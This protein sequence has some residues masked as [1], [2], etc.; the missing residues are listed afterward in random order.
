MIKQRLSNEEVNFEVTNL[1]NY[2]CPVCPRGKMTREKGVMDLN[3]FK[4]LI[5]AGTQIGLKRVIL[6]GFGEPFLDKT[7]FEKTRY[8]K[9]YGLEVN[10]ATNGYLLNNE[11]IDALLES[12]LDELR[13]S[14]FS[15][16]P[17]LYKK[18]HGLDGYRL[19]ANNLMLLLEKRKIK[20]SRFPRIGIYYIEHP[21]NV[22]QIQDFIEAWKDKVDGLEVWKAHNWINA[23]EL[24][25]GIKTKKMCMRPLKGP[26]QIRWNGDIVPCCFD[27]NNEMVIGNVSSGSYEDLFNDPR[28]KKII[29]AHKKGNLAEYPLCERCDQLYDT[30]DALI[31]TTNKK[32]RA[33]FEAQK[34]S[35]RPKK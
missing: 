22:L 26:M 8:A 23:Y 3:L 4:K 10:A 25:K 12:E 15:F 20:K 32:V 13:F 24:R 11:K 16:N 33:I 19:V 1:C 9:K 21:E 29:E 17:Q 34:L 14:I 2:K 35:Q 28:Y 30:P 7:V 27:F 31:Y 18:L 6:T 5:D